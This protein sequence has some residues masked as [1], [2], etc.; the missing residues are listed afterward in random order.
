MPVQ[1]AGVKAML[2]A[3]LMSATA[4]CQSQVPHS[5]QA[6]GFQA[7]SVTAPPGQ[8]LMTAPEAFGVAAVK[9]KTRTAPPPAVTDTAAAATLNPAEDLP[10]EV[11]GW[12]ND[13]WDNESHAV[14]AKYA[15]TFSEVNPSWYNLGSSDGGAAANKSDGSIY[16][17]GYVYDAA[18]VALVHLNHDLVIPTIGDN[19]AG[20]LNAILN[21]A[22][23]RQ[24]LLD[25]LVSTAVSRNY[26]GFDLNFE[27]GKPAG[28]AAFASFVDD[29]AKALHQ[30]GKRLSVTLKAADSATAEAREIFDYKRLGQTQADRF[31]VMMY[32]HNFDAG[33][34]V[35]GPIADY[36]WMVDSLSYMIGRG[37]PANKIQLGLHNYAWVWK[38]QSGGFSLQAPFSTWSALQGRS[39][40]WNSRS[41]ESWSEFQ[42]QGQNYQAYVG[43]AQTV[44][45]RLPLVRRF[46]LAG[47]VFWTLGRE[48][49]R[50]YTSLPQEFPA[51]G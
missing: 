27:L 43:D 37:L 23:A 46:G 38:Q 5:L 48:D 21:H 4:A 49:Q 50:I 26:D 39:L 44:A 12:Y 2:L 16:E 19:K 15:N 22:T 18:K 25:H 11:A 47:V 36:G 41:K 45:E 28:Q 13:G 31:K 10:I 34:D 7:A 9:G 14:Y 20:Q 30:V 42:Y 6:P 24:A 40:Q 3:L 8:A 29:L 1:F 33:A 35:P 17:R 51:A 32:D